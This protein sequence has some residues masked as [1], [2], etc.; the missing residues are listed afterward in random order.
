MNATQAGEQPKLERAELIWNS[1]GEAVV[2]AG[3]KTLGFDELE[4]VSIAHRFPQSLRVEL[5]PTQV[6][7]DQGLGDVSFWVLAL[8]LWML[9]VEVEPILPTLETLTDAPLLVTGHEPGRSCEESS[10]SDAGPLQVRRLL[11]RLHQLSLYKKGDFLF[12]AHAARLRC[13]Y[14]MEHRERG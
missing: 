8:P 9:R 7:A 14:R 6:L 4:V 3:G 1:A 10:W 11:P 2:R 5:K 12:V 13:V